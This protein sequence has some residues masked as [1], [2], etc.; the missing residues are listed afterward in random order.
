MCVSDC[1]RSEHLWFI[2]FTQYKP[3]IPIYFIY[4]NI[5]GRFLDWPRLITNYWSQTFPPL[6]HGSPGTIP[7][8]PGEPTVHTVCAS[9]SLL[10]MPGFL[11]FQVHMKNNTKKGRKE[12]NSLVFYPSSVKSGV[13]DQNMA[14][15]I[16]GSTL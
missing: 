5:L 3:N 7:G 12:G 1:Q 4:A 6:P 2:C 10:G 16:Q 15:F 13:L 14:V 11:R 8:W 9:S